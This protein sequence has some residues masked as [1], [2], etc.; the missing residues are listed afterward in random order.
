MANIFKLDIIANSKFLRL[1]AVNSK[2][3]QCT[4]DL[5]H[6]IVI[7]FFRIAEKVFDNS[8]SFNPS[9]DMLN[10]NPDAGDTTVLLFL[11]WGKLFSFGFL[12]RLKRLH[13]LWFIPLKASIFIHID[14]CMVCGTFFISN[15]FIMPFAFIGLTQII[16]FACMEAAKNEVLDRV[17][18]FLPL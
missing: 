12:P 15:L 5:H 14:V 1:P 6:K 13:S 10:N 3:V 9:N 4:G 7:L 17:R 11:F 16:D 18:F 2:V 8:T